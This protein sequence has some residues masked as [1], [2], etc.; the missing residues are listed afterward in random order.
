MIAETPDFRFL[1]FLSK[2]V[3]IDEPFAI[4]KR[5]NGRLCDGSSSVAITC[6]CSN[7]RGR[8]TWAV[9]LKVKSQE[10]SRER[11]ETCEAELPSVRM[12]ILYCDNP[13]SLEPGEHNW[14]PFTFGDTL[15]EYMDAVTSQDDQEREVM[16][17]YKPSITDTEGLVKEPRSVHIVDLDPKYQIDE[18]VFNGRFNCMKGVM[19]QSIQAIQIILRQ[20]VGCQAKMMMLPFSLISFT[21]MCV[22]CRAHFVSN[23]LPTYV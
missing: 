14:D 9:N 5:C 3:S 1:H 18:N 2:T 11:L 21:S 13:N 15:C 6:L 22:T 20:T 7:E 17:W 23:F 19:I 10:L 16:G 12:R 4:P 8:S